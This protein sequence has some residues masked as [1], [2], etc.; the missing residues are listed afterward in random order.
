MTPPQVEKITK[1]LS[2]IEA[3]L[4]ALVFLKLRETRTDRFS[5]DSS[6][7]EPVDKKYCDLINSYI[8]K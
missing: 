4:E 7:A 1:L 2:N 8:R 6:L 5:R 3:H